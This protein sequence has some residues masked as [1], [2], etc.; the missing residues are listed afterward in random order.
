M[1]AKLVRI[2]NSRGIRLPKPLI[3]EAGLDR[4]GD[5]VELRRRAW[6]DRDH[7]GSFAAFG[8]VR[9]RGIAR[10][11]AVIRGWSTSRKPLDSSGRS[12]AW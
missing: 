9:G 12:G 3:E 7:L 8:V 10:E 4:D 11:V 6:L 2:G 5:E 1:R